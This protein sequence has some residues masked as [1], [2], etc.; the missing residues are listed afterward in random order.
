METDRGSWRYQ[1]LCHQERS[2]SY[3]RYW[4]EDGVHRLEVI[5]KAH[6]GVAEHELPFRA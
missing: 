6:L 4:A 5:Q 1:Q 3:I 2:V